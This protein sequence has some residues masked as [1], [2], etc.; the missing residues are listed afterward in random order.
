VQEAVAGSRSLLQALLRHLQGDAELL[1]GG[2]VMD[3][4]RLLRVV[5]AGH[6][7]CQLAVAQLPGAV[8]SLVQLLGSGEGEVGNEA[9]VT[10][11]VLQ[12][13]TEEVQQVVREASKGVQIVLGEA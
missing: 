7:G 13:G 8:A 5:V 4:L 3:V 6:E 2:V 11:A 9:A 10:L 1:E 12:S